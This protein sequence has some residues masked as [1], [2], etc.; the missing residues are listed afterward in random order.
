[1]DFGF[2]GLEEAVLADW[3]ASLWPP[4]DPFVRALMTLDH[5][6]KLINAGVTSHLLNAK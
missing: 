3:L 4:N 6:L 1:M 5:F 2:K